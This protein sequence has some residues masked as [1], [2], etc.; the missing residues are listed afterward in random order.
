[1]N[2]I[3]FID[4]SFGYE[5]TFQQ[6]ECSPF[7]SKDLLSFSCI[8]AEKVNWCDSFSI[9]PLIICIS[10]ISLR[11]LWAIRIQKRCSL[12]EQATLVILLI[13]SVVTESILTIHCKSKPQPAMHCWFVGIKMLVFW[14][15]VVIACAVACWWWCFCYYIPS[16][17]FTL[18]AYKR[19]RCCSLYCFFFFRFIDFHHALHLP[20]LQIISKLTE[21]GEKRHQQQ[22]KVNKQKNDCELAFR[23]KMVSLSI[24]RFG[25]C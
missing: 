16:D 5:T 3:K 24:I 9:I 13:T 17:S 10:I 22:Q 25:S 15:C 19:V 1:M 8:S 23:W 14:I 20:L 18:A 12:K 11:S 7:N 21:K 6:I 2:R 4:T